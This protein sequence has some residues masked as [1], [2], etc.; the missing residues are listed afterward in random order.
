MRIICPVRKT[1]SENILN[2]RFLQRHCTKATENYVSIH[3][4]YI[5]FAIPSDLQAL[6]S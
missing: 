5:L 2:T 6:M 4:K 1:I 3:D